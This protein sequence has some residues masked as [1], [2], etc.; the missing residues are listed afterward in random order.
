MNG[1]RRGWHAGWIGVVL[2]TILATNPSGAVSLDLRG[3]DSEN[4]AVHGLIDTAVKALEDKRG[5]ESI[6]IFRQILRDY[7]D[8][9]L[10][11]LVYRSLGQVYL[12]NNDPVNAG[13]FF[14]KFIEEFPGSADLDSVTVTG[15]GKIL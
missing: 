8:T 12:E 10:R 4:F 7:P 11:G 9:P 3:D 15:G 14:K 2:S 5:N 1:I 6:A 13:F